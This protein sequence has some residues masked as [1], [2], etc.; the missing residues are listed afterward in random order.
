MTTWVIVADASRAR[1]F[2]AEK[3]FSPLVE[4][5]DFTHLEARL[6]EQDIQSDR[7]GRVFDSVGDGR[8]ALGKEDSPKKHEATRF[9]KI[10]CEHL[11]LARAQGQFE[12][13]Y[14]I[15]APAFLGALRNCMDAVTQKSIAGELNKNLTTHDPED[16]RK[17]LPQFL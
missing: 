3:S 9:A 13:L 6:T 2:S 5:Q 7:M 15:A 11:N 1:L 16:I 4:E 12:K 14:V 8:H 17:Q 10:L